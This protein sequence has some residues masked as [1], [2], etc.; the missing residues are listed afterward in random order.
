M[1]SDEVRA[2]LRAKAAAYQPDRGAILDLIHRGQATLDPVETPR[3]GRRRTAVR[4]AA[5]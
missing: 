2:A 4:P 3:A 5:T 1:S